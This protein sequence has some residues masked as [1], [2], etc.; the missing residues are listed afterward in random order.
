MLFIFKH[1]LA[2]LFFIGSLHAETFIIEGIP[3]Y[4]ENTSTDAF[5]PSTNDS[6]T[7]YD[8]P[9]DLFDEDEIVKLPETNEIK[10]L[11][12]PKNPNCLRFELSSHYK[13]IITFNLLHNSSESSNQITSITIQSDQPACPEELSKILK[14][15]IQRTNSA[16]LELLSNIDSDDEIPFSADDLNK[17]EAEDIVDSF[18]TM[19]S[20]QTRRASPIPESFDLKPSPNIC[21]T[22]Q[23][24]LYES[25]FSDSTKKRRAESMPR[26]A[27]PPPPLPSITK[28]IRATKK[29]PIKEK[30]HQSNACDKSFTEKTHLEKHTKKH[31]GEGS[32]NCDF[33]DKSFKSSL[34]L[35][36]HT[37]THTGERP[38]KCDECGAEFTQNSNLTTHSL[39]HTGKRPF[40]CYVCGMTFTQNSNLRRHSLTH[41]GQKPYQCDE[42]GAE[43]TQKDSLTRHNRTH[44]GERPFKC[45]VCEVT[46]TQ[47]AH[48]A[49][50]KKTHSTENKKPL[51]RPRRG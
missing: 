23:Q 38:F 16:S 7:F 26:A 51:K 35:A 9:C 48:L 1:F 46:F 43:F 10:I 45:D 27:A 28:V 21:S 8:L 17:A 34:N 41:T 6:I 25:L 50:H 29:A 42:C 13:A 5:P 20:D 24:I 4:H 18:T 47:S 19:F 15:I 12:T 22:I 31:S 11:P 32:F 3:V 2:I 39:T 40:K 36:D 30:T 44:T 37:R 14:T 49:T 33:C